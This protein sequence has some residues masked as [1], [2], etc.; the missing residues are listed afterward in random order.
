MG[1]IACIGSCLILGAGFSGAEES[2]G[3]KRDSTDKAVASLIHVL[4][5]EEWPVRAHAVESLGEI[6]EP[7]VAKLKDLL[8]GSDETLRIPSAAALTAIGSKARSTLVEATKDER[9]DVR[10]VARKALKLV[11]A[12]APPRPKG[13]KRSARGNARHA[14]WRTIVAM[15]WVRTG[16]TDDGAG[17]P[18]K[19]KEDETLEIRV[20]SVK[21]L[22]DAVGKAQLGDRAANLVEFLQVEVRQDSW[23]DDGGY[24]TIQFFRQALVIRHRRAGHEEVAG[25]LNSLR[26][27]IEMVDPQPRRSPKLRLRR[28][29][30]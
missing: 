6:G 2:G 27:A 22:V 18:G 8:V 15:V 13:G 1:R 24:A 3:A 5:D 23:T 28:S 30:S 17:A 4:G 20:Y 12:D 29:A 14:N 21:D 25:V 26:R 16:P 7:A 9:P 11:D 10:Q 19:K